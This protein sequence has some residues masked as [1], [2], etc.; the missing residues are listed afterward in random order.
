[1]IQDWAASEYT[2]SD[3]SIWFALYREDGKIDDWTFIDNVERGRFRLHPAGYQGIS[4]GCITLPS[5]AH[6]AILR[7]ALLKTPTLQ[8]TSMLTAYGTVQVY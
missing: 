4:Q 5:R 8:V 1:M 2:G 6:F 7:E 3:R